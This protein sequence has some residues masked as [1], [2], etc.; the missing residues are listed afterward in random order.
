MYIAKFVFF[1]VKAAHLEVVTECLGHLFVFQYFVRTS[2]TT[3]N[4]PLVGDS[5]G[6]H[7]I[8]KYLF[9]C[10]IIDG[11]LPRWTRQITPYALA[12]VV[13]LSA[14]VSRFIKGSGPPPSSNVN[15]V[16]VPDAIEQ[17]HPLPCVCR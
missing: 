13:L 16:F 10:A 7:S 5:I 14:Y 3:L 2:M 11:H 17:P 15:F 9:A 1:T 8:T 6:P 4:S 12:V